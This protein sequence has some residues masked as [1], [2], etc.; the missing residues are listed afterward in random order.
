MV[1]QQHIQAAETRLYVC[2]QA[3][4]SGSIHTMAC[5][6][7]LVEQ[8]KI[9]VVYAILLV[10]NASPANK[11]QNKFKPGYCKDSECTFSC[12]INFFKFVILFIYFYFRKCIYRMP[13]KH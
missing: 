2:W 12:N 13:L 8:T 9:T 11:C 6:Q 5:L 4:K 7:I 1:G 10:L 3:L